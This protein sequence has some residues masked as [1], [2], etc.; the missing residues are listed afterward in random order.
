VKR[1]PRS[2]SKLPV[3]ALSSAP[4]LGSLPTSLL[5][6]SP[7][8]PLH[9]RRSSPADPRHRGQPA[10]AI[11]RSSRPHPKHRAAEFI[12]PDCSDPT[13]DPYSGLPQSLPYRRSPPAQRSLPVS[14]SP[15]FSRQTGLSP[16]RLAPRPL[17][18]WP[19]ASRIS[20][21]THRC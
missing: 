15:L 18:R 12:L 2:P 11:L 1:H 4:M 14:S 21:A 10:P 19:P 6:P 20:L 13:G 16:C 17:H 8:P 7:A 9:H 3:T 5:A